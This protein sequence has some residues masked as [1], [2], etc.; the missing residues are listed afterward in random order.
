MEENPH[1]TSNLRVTAA[2]MVEL[3]RLG[4][5]SRLGKMVLKA[6]PGFSVSD[7]V[8]RQAFQ[9]PQLRREFGQKLLQAGLPD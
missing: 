4:E 3:G 2:S 5:A 8:K 9:S 7:F 1:Y 6:E